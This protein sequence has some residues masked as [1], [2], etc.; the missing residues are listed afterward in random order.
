LL[1]FL[2]LLL[3]LPLTFPRPATDPS[4]SQNPSSPNLLRPGGNGGRGDGEEGAPVPAAEGLPRGGARAARGPHPPLRH[5]HHHHRLL[6]LPL[7]LRRRAL[8]VT[9]SPSPPGF[10]SC[11][12][13][14]SAQPPEFRKPSGG[15]CSVVVQLLL[16]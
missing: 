9:T 13:S 16:L 3:L 5:H 6:L 4:S 15:I 11:G 14:R 2:L 10:C 8:Q 1:C 7:P 12:L